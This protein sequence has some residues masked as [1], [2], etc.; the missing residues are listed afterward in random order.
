MWFVLTGRL[1]AAVAAAVTVVALSLAT[2]PV[3]GLGPWLDYP[4]V[5][6]NLSPPTELS[7]VLAPSAW[8]AE[9]LPA[10]IAQVLVMAAG[11]ATVAW[12]AR[13]R[14]PVVGFSVTVAVAILVTP[15]LYP[16]YL[17]IMVLPLLV[18]VRYVRPLG[19]VVVA[20]VLMLGIEIDALGEARLFVNRA[21]LSIGPLVLVAGLI[22]SGRA[23]DGRDVGAT[24][25]RA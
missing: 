7:F 18:A 3:V 4:T 8:L 25:Q 20:Y 19:W 1:R 12:V 11:L 5:L 6:L 23:G 22:W 13:R 17:A 2:L 10:R 24:G 9:I 15:A 16:H 14:S 21:L